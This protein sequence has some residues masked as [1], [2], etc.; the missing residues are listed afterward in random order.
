MTSPKPGSAT[1]HGSPSRSSPV[2]K[3]QSSG[4]ADLVDAAIS[5]GAVQAQRASKRSS[6]RS[7]SKLH[8]N[9]ATT[10]ASPVISYT[11]EIVTD[12]PSLV[13]DCCIQGTLAPPEYLNEESHERLVDLLLRSEMQ[14]EDRGAHMACATGVSSLTRVARRTARESHVMGEESKGEDDEDEREPGR[15]AQRFINVVH[16][17]IDLLRRGTSGAVGPGAADLL[18]LKLRKLDQGLQSHARVRSAA[19]AREIYA[20][21]AKQAMISD[22][23]IGQGMDLCRVATYQKTNNSKLIMEEGRQVRGIYLILRGS[24]TFHKKNA[25]VSLTQ[26]LAACEAA[27]KRLAAPDDDATKQQPNRSRVVEAEDRLGPCVMT[28][29]APWSFGEW[30]FLRGAES[31]YSVV[32]QPGSELLLL[33][34][35]EISHTLGKASNYIMLASEVARLASTHP[36]VRSREDSALLADLIR[37][38]RVLER[39]PHQ[40]MDELATLLHTEEYDANELLFVQGEQQPCMFIILQGSVSIMIQDSPASPEDA[41]AKVMEVVREKNDVVDQ[42]GISH[43]DPGRAA[44]QRSRTGSFSTSGAQP[45]V[46]KALMASITSG[47]TGQSALAGAVLS[48]RGASPEGK[49]SGTPL[50]DRIGTVLSVVGEHEEHVPAAQKEAGSGDGGEG[51]Q[52][53]HVEAAA[54]AARIGPEKPAR[55]YSRTNTNEGRTT[56]SRRASRTH[57]KGTG[58][59]TSM[60][61]SDPRGSGVEG[62]PRGAARSKVADEVDAMLATA[63]GAE[64]TS[65]YGEPRVRVRRFLLEDDADV[66]GDAVDSIGPGDACGQHGLLKQSQ[67]RSA[68]AIAEQKTRAIVVPRDMFMSLF[69]LEQKPILHAP[70]VRKAL[71]THPTQ[72]TPADNERVAELLDRSGL[73]ARF[74]PRI[75]VGICQNMRLLRRGADEVIYRQGDVADAYYIVLSG[76][77]SVHVKASNMHFNKAWEKDIYGQYGAAADLRGVGQS[78]GEMAL[79]KQQCKRL[80]TVI[81]QDPAE[82]VMV[83]RTAF[84]SLMFRVEAEERVSQSAYLRKIPGL[85]AWD[86]VRLSALAQAFTELTVARGRDVI[87]P[88]QLPGNETLYF[89]SK[90]TVSVRYKLGTAGF[91]SMASAV[92]TTRGRGKKRAS[93]QAAHNNAQAA[94]AVSVGGSKPAAAVAEALRQKAARQRRTQTLLAHTGAELAVI[95]TGQWFGEME[96]VI[97]ETQKRIKKQQKEEEDDR[98]LDLRHLSYVAIEETVM[99][100]IQLSDFLDAVR[101]DSRAMQALRTAAME[102]RS[103]LMDRCGLIMDTLITVTEEGHATYEL[104][105]GHP[106]L[107]AANPLNKRAVHTITGGDGHGYTLPT[108]AKARAERT[109]SPQRN[110]SPDRRN[111]SPTRMAA[112]LDGDTGHASPRLPAIAPRTGKSMLGGGGSPM[113]SPGHHPHPTGRWIGSQAHH[114]SPGVAAGLGGEASGPSSPRRGLPGVGAPPAGLRAAKDGPAAATAAA[115]TLFSPAR[116]F[117]GAMGIGTLRLAKR[118]PESPPPPVYGGADRDDV[119][120]ES[121]LKRRDASSP[122]GRGLLLGTGRAQASR[123]PT[124]PDELLRTAPPLSKHG[125]VPQRGG[126]Q[127]PGRTPPRAHFGTGSPRVLTELMESVGVSSPSHMST[128]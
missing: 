54:G 65:L 84:E 122:L 13:L 34:A 94:H 88:G 14:A 49:G 118:A 70:E 81:V 41:Y 63:D 128:L 120:P 117:G 123:G 15:A 16:R 108:T 4:M 51:A 9:A 18:S 89:I 19:V 11:D 27:S 90:G 36:V 80:S 67:P 35:S 50:D 48:M 75:H 111:M 93:L 24:V 53:S 37:R 96:T 44:I 52:G 115:E 71:R 98:T 3:K 124:I 85:S 62:T 78:F 121:L 99:H 101:E 76:L 12:K 74:D 113:R 59:R 55:S 69:L 102:K 73:L 72:R 82:L 91:A 21:V 105:A 100:C 116:G 64:D 109:P 126:T 92:A 45:D 33:P 112:L 46:V 103:F 61:G 40:Y 110:A 39:L 95:S 7:P 31:Q 42:F 77:V 47:T 56:P 23:P 38:H 125:F 79:S 104:Q 127:A 119:L 68:S 43:G 58:S 66:M 83:P 107:D 32:A 10:A 30:N 29:G 25:P 17:V 26:R 1:E 97:A 22:L 114:V 57:L 2:P 106:L 60:T 86:P 6:F 5:S 28:L 8:M 20:L 87:A